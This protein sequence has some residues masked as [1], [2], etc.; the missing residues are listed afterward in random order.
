MTQKHQ[1]SVFSDFAS[2]C[3]SNA[4]KK[5]THR[6]T[7]TAVGNIHCSGKVLGNLNFPI[8]PKSSQNCID[9]N[10]LRYTKT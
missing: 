8:Y 4:G 2:K 5:G 10:S 6:R 7:E 9:I 1:N 3:K